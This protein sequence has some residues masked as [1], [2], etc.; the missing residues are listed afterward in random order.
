VKRWPILVF[1]LAF[2]GM[3]CASA[4]EGPTTPAQAMDACCAPLFGKWRGKGWIAQTDGR[5]VD[6]DAEIEVRLSESGESALFIMKYTPLEAGEGQAVEKV[7]LL[8]FMRDGWM[9]TRDDPIE[10]FKFTPYRLRYLLGG[11]FWG[12]RFRSGPFG[13]GWVEPHPGG[14]IVR[15]LSPNT[16][17]AWSIA[18]F[19]CSNSDNDRLI[20]YVLV[21]RVGPLGKQATWWAAGR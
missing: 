18:G 3:P 11:P 6:I 21:T 13:E 15:Y 12:V 14:G 2:L 1:L 10:E 17:T 16:E 20:S 5:H 4:S 19:C 8:T 9:V 7:A